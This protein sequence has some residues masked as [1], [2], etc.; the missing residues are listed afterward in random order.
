MV[1]LHRGQVD[2]HAQVDKALVVPLAQ[3]L[4]GL[5]QHPF[6]NRDYGAVL[7]GQRDENVRRD[8]AV[9]RMLPA[10]QRLDADHPVVAVID[11]WLINQVQ[12]VVGEGFAQGFF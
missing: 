3:L 6:A 11:L 5:I 12:L 8:K 9:L 2:R 4:A 10:Q 7:F 1:Q